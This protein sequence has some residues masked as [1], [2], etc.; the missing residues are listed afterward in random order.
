MIKYFLRNKQ[1]LFSFGT[2]TFQLKLAILFLKQTYLFGG[3]LMNY[4]DI[5]TSVIIKG[6]IIMGYHNLRS[7]HKITVNGRKKN[8]DL[9]FKILKTNQNTEFGK[10][11]HFNSIKSVEQYRNTVP[12]TTFKDYEDY[13]VRM[14]DNN[15]TNLITALPLVGY[16]QSSGSV[17]KRKFIPLTRDSVNVYTN[18]TVPRMLALA[19]KYYKEQGKKGLIAG[20]G[21]YTDPAYND[22]LPNGLPCSNAADVPAKE[23]AFIYPYILVSP[24][25]RMFTA[26]EVDYRYLSFRFALEDK[27]TMYFFGVFFKDIADHIKY[28]ENNWRILADDI[29]FGRISPLAKA[30]PEIEEIIKKTLSPN[31]LRA[32]E[33]RQECEK[34]FNS[35]I[36]K[37]LWPNMQIISSIGTSTFEPFADLTRTYAYSIPFD[38]S[39]YGA[40][41]GLF[42]ATDSIESKKQLLLLESCY[43]EF[44]SIDDGNDTNKILSINELEIGK[45]YEIVITNQSGLYR[46]RCGDVIIVLDYLNDCPYLQFAYRKGQLL[47]LTGEKT[48]EEHMREVID[49]IAK[50]AGCTIQHWAA[51]N[52][53]EDHPYHYVL[54][55]ENEEGIDLTP[56][57]NYAHEALKKINVRYEYFYN[58]QGMDALVIKNLKSG[59]NKAWMKKKIEE[60][61]SPSQVKPVRILDNREKMDFFLSRIK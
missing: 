8:D 24:I 51:Y 37:R 33:I 19:D 9:L 26:D 15:E 48:T 28:L 23:L 39:I 30:A 12:L 40:S 38:F 17:G 47:N 45:H 29:E 1:C 46:Y 14:I 2:K 31:P 50:K 41:E 18:Y 27:R 3:I 44:I 32:A 6:M 58:T 34:G 49:R 13:I 54:L 55:I 4:R 5:L 16:A 52:S 21:I 42:A 56:Y 59:T 61:V 11:Y 36:L 53:T 57:S 35:T 25:P 7:M 10:K 60:G 43:Y 22:F 20:R